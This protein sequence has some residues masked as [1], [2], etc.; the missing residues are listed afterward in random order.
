MLDSIIG[1]IM[2]MTSD[3]YIQQ[4]SQS[5][6][7]IINRQWV[8]D[9]T[10]PCKIE[11]MKSGGALNRADNKAFESQGNNEYTERFQLKMKSPVQL[12]RRSR[13]SNIRDN[14]GSIIYV[15]FDI[16]DQP[17]MIFEVTSSHAEID[18]LGYVS[19]YETTLQ[20]VLI[21]Y[22]DTSNNSTVQPG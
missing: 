15:E 9:Q 4:N 1:S 8:Y 14:S 5:Q 11:P 17:A 6:S 10:I 12:S 7:G 3:I 21:Q 2:N 19:Y 20:R 18:P 22:D 16:Y 13:I